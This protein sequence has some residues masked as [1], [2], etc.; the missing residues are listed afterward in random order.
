MECYLSKKQY[1]MGTKGHKP[2]SNEKK[3]VKSILYNATHN[4]LHF[5]IK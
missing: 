4:K 5:T 2:Q 3:S 1:I